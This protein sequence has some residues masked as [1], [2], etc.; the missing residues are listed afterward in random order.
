MGPLASANQQIRDA[1]R[2]WIEQ[3]LARLAA[4]HR[5]TD[6]LLNQLEELNL[7]GVR[8][9]PQQFE[10]PLG[11]LRRQLVGRPGLTTRLLDRLQTGTRTTELIETVFTIQ[12]VIAPPTLPPGAYPFDDATLM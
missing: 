4:P 12:E 1:E 8:T 11:E 9:V 10:T 7:D 5:L 2:Q 6:R 3:R